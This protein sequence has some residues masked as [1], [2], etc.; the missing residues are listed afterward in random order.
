MLKIIQ[1][2]LKYT[3]CSTHYKTKITAVSYIRPGFQKAQCKNAPN[4]AR[5]KLEARI[6]ENT[7]QFSKKTA[8]HVHR[9][10]LKCKGRRMAE[11]C[12][13]TLGPRISQPP[14][15]TKENFEGV[16]FPSHHTVRG[17]IPV[18]VSRGPRPL[19]PT[20]VPTGAGPRPHLRAEA[21][22]RPPRA[23]GSVHLPSRV[24][25]HHREVA[26]GCSRSPR[27]EPDWGGAERR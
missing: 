14:S 11:R 27:P 18:P 24:D 17:P 26:L 4:Q 13:Q 5:Q 8:E 10:K 21:A 3:V 12:R 7:L 25:L 2:N 15:K 20:P 9:S 16:R 19:Q 1:P 23:V 22:V 6:K